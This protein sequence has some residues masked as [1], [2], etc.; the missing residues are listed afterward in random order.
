MRLYP[1]RLIKIL[2]LLIL[3]IAIF[4]KIYLQTWHSKI[5]IIPIERKFPTVLTSNDEFNQISY[6][7]EPFTAKLPHF[8]DDEA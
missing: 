8:S 3:F 1:I 7:L 2:I 4:D 5:K 6:T